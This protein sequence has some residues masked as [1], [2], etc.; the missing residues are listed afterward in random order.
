[1][2]KIG[3]SNKV[4]AHLKHELRQ[5]ILTAPTQMPELKKEIARVFQVA[6]RRIQNVEKSGLISPAVLALNKQDIE[7]YSKFSVGGKSW[8]ELK[9]EYGKAIEFL[10]QPTSSA[11]GAREYAKH[12]QQSYDL[13]DDEFKLMSA[14]MMNKLTSVKD[15]DFVERYLMRYKDFS[16]E[17]ETMAN[18]I[19]QQL[20]DEAT[21]L[22]QALIEEIQDTAVDVL[23]SEELKNHKKNIPDI[24][25]LT[26]LDGN[27]IKF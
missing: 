12:I 5:D 3:F 20:E 21:Q 26:D 10:R 15:I 9:M 23:N 16:G 4:F 14:S 27:G 19:S 8:Q 18:D 1:M 6:N 22:E 2:A 25:D 11:T 13:T 7:G 17:I 24:F